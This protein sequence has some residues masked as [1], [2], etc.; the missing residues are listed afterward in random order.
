V[1]EWDWEWEWEC[2]G[3]AQAFVGGGRAAARVGWVEYIY[4]F[5]LVFVGF[6]WG[7]GG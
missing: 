4:G 2:G 6:L 3:R 5:Q 7:E 1:T